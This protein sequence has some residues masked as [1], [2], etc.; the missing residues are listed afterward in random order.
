MMISLV[1]GGGGEVN[2]YLLSIIQKL[3]C[4]INVCILLS[5]DEFHDLLSFQMQSEPCSEFQN[6][7]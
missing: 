2:K 4:Y 7:L 3:N 6:P 1:H 5:Y